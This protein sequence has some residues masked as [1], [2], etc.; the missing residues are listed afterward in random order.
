[1]VVRD[2]IVGL[3]NVRSRCPVEAPKPLELDH[4]STE[5]FDAKGDDLTSKSDDIFPS[6]PLNSL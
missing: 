6:S 5:G 3:I 4:Q 2:M 1:M